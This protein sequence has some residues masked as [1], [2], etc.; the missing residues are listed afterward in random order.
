[1]SV[2]NFIC[3]WY[4]ASDGNFVL[5]RAFVLTLIVPFVFRRFYLL[6]ILCCWR[7][8]RGLQNELFFSFSSVL[9]FCFC[10]VLSILRQ[11]FSSMKHWLFW[12]SVC[13]RGWPRNHKDP[14]AFTSQGLG[15]KKCLAMPSPCFCF[16][17][18]GSYCVAQAAWKSIILLFQLPE[19]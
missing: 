14:P 2:N 6:F 15:V 12:N 9:G 3:K 7:G 17:E 13:R 8:R 19:G 10:F 18:T 4:K 11:G 5:L 16:L 1:M